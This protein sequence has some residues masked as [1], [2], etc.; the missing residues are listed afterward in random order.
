VRAVA[1]RGQVLALRTSRVRWLGVGVACLATLLTL[2]IV[3]FA[4]FRIVEGRAF[5]YGRIAQEQAELFEPRAPVPVAAPPEV[6]SSGSPV[7]PGGDGRPERTPAVVVPHPFLGFVYDPESPLLKQHQGRGAMELTEHGFFRLPGPVQKGEAL[8]V[9]VFGG[10]VA[11]YF[12]VD[13]REALERALAAHP[14]FRGRP[15]SIQCFALGGFKQPQM[16]AALAYLMALGHRFDVVVELDGFNDVVLSFLEHRHKGVYPFYP[17]DW[18]RL[19][20]RAPDLGEQQRIGLIAYLQGRRARLARRFARPPLSWSVTGS[21]VWS[22]LDRRL[23]AELGA[24]RQDLATASR[25]GNQYRERGPS[26]RYASEHE[27]LQDIARVWGLSSLQMQRL[28][29]GAGTRYHHFLQPNQYAPGGKPMGARER[30][31]AYLPDHP[32]RRPAELGYPLLQ[33]EGAR[34]RGLGVEFH[35]LSALFAG[36]AEPLYADHCCHLNAKGNQLLG[37]AV[38]KAI[39]ASAAV[40]EAASPA[41]GGSSASTGPRLRHGRGVD[42]G[43]PP[44]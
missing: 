26:R 4:L 21:L 36:I 41:G 34:L 42:F 43:A 22:R 3:S 19:V 24:A 38:G 18:D 17:R 39:T 40:A 31:A 44:R 5:S 33:R 1:S 25:P 23:A 35:D 12:S 6:F 20:E 8:S 32:Y 28:C 13:G 30:A 10:S 27:L 9:A 7:V 37:E 16:A 29:A 11:A 14:V 15:L 2:E